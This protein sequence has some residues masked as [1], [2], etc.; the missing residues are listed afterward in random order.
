MKLDPDMKCAPSKK[1]TN[2]SCFT[3][4]A[5]QQIATNYNNRQGVKKK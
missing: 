4:K 5:L 1:Y 2:G 3:Y